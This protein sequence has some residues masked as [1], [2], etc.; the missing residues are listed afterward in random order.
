MLASGHLKLIVQV[1]SHCIAYRWR[2]CHVGV[3]RHHGRAAG[4]RLRC[5]LSLP[6]E[7]PNCSRAAMCMR[8]ECSSWPT[9]TA[10]ALLTR[11]SSRRATSLPCARRALSLSL[12]RARS[13][14]ACPATAWQS[15]LSTRGRH[16]HRPHWRCWSS[17]TS[18][19]WKSL[20][21]SASAC[22]HHPAVRWRQCQSMVVLRVCVCVGGC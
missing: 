11:K 14:Y 13:A 3:R 8:S 12:S 15:D 19:R 17:R 7:G 22:G 1:C 5:T 9:G 4:A 10:T 6:L 20:S 16:T 2:C 21:G 18:K